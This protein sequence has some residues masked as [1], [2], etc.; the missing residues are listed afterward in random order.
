MGRKAERVD[1]VRT[2]LHRMHSSSS[3]ITGDTATAAVPTKA[4]LD[5]T[6]ETKKGTNE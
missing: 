4:T 3:N 2:M 1:H 6:N 5:E